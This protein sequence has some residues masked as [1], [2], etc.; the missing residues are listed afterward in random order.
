MNGKLVMNF[1][2]LYICTVFCLILSFIHSFIH[3]FKLTLN[4]SP[5]CET[6]TYREK[7]TLT[8]VAY[9]KKE[10]VEH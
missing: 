10:K 8:G 3:S 4:R 7:R 2:L 9:L 1:F 5:I 6:T